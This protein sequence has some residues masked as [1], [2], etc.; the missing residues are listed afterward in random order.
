MLP[1]LLAFLCLLSLLQVSQAQKSEM[2]QVPDTCPVTTPADQPFV[3]PPPYSAKVGNGRFWFGT[4]RL[5]TNLPVNGM[6]RGL[7][8]DTTAAHPTSFE[9]LFW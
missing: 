9:K 6:L 3:P 1:K 7:P 8:V 2:P 4:D 5:W